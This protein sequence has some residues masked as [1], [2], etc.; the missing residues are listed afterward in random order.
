MTAVSGSAFTSTMASTI[1]FP[2]GMLSRATTT[3]ETGTLVSEPGEATQLRLLPAAGVAVCA[4]AVLYS[5]FAPWYSDRRLQD[6]Y[7]A[8]G[9]ADL[10]EAA[11]FAR[12]AHNLDPLALEPIQ[13][14]R[15]RGL[16]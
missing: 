13:L 14:L 15:G 16:V 2:A 11:S 8:A 5:L 1:F 6:A 7:D 9:R 10:V 4:L 12:D 3:D